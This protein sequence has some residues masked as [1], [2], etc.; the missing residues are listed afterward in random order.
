MRDT[1]V[2]MQRARSALRLR[3]SFFR[4]E[5]K[6]PNPGQQD[7]WP[8]NT[9]LLRSDGSA[10]PALRTFRDAIAVW[11]REPSPEL[12]EKPASAGARARRPPPPRAP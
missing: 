2:L 5:D 6:A 7:S 8:L 9:G 3:G 1:I 4:W 10:K 11:R 12:A